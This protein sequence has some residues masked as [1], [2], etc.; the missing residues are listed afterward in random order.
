MATTLTAKP[1]RT[2]ALIGLAL[3]GVAVPAA[4]FIATIVQ[5]LDPDNVGAGD[6]PEWMLG[7]TVSAGLA[8]LI[9]LVVLVAGRGMI[10]TRVIVILLVVGGLIVAGGQRYAAGVQQGYEEAAATAPEL[11]PTPTPTRGCGPDSPPVFG[12]QN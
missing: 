3:F 7:A 10:A 4:S 1:L 2:V 6:Q 12:D 8:V 5:S 11:T 9:G